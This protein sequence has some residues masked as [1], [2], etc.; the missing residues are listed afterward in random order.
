M[1]LTDTQVV[2]KDLCLG[3]LDS[4]LERIHFPRQTKGMVVRGDCDTSPRVSHIFLVH[5]LQCRVRLHACVAAGLSSLGAARR[6]GAEW[7]VARLGMQKGWCW[8]SRVERLLVLRQVGEDKQQ[9]VV[10]AATPPVVVAAAPP[11]RRHAGTTDNG[12]AEGFSGAGESVTGGDSGAGCVASP[13]R[14]GVPV[15]D[16][17]RGAARLQRPRDRQGGTLRHRQ[18]HHGEV[19]NALRQNTARPSRVAVA[20]ISAL[21]QIIGLVARQNY[22]NVLGR[23]LVALGNEGQNVKH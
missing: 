23:W 8:L 9:R 19:D 16:R 1:S 7:E 21:L 2:G 20:S 6:E 15:R 14:S 4:N 18:I 13:T 11:S 22:F 10:V 17:S 5:G 12:F 3:W